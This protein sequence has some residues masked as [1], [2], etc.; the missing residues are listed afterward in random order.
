MFKLFKLRLAAI[1][2]LV[3]FSTTALPAETYEIDTAHSTLNFRAKRMGIV[4]VYG[5]FR[6]I[7]GTI[8]L[9]GDDLVA[10]SISLTVKTASV[11]SGNERRDNHLRSPDFLNSTE[12]PE[13]TFK[14]KRVEAGE[15][16]VFNVVGDLSLHGITKEVIVPVGQVGSGK[17]P[18]SGASLIGFDGSFTLQRSDFGMSFMVG[19]ISDDIDIRIAIQAVSR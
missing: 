3:V 12:L 6:D 10:G 1:I 11:D 2:A 17:D 9:P 15:A 14:S 19:P 8:E 16:G 7:T 18:R 13:M 4:Y 5:A